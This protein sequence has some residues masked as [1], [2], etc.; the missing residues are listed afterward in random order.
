MV[1]YEASFVVFHAENLTLRTI[2]YLGGSI[3]FWQT[4]PI[5]S[6][7]QTF[8]FVLCFFGIMSAFLSYVLT[9]RF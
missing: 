7:E 8:Q 2:L 4:L 5:D 3:M 6:I 1:S 9:L